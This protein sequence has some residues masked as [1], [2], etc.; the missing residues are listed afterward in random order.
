MNRNAIKALRSTAAVTAAVL[1]VAESAFPM[2]IF[3]GRVAETNRSRQTS[4]SASSAESS[5][6]TTYGI[7]RH[8]LTLSSNGQAVTSVRKGARFSVIERESGRLKVKL[9]DG[10]TGWVDEKGVKVGDDRKPLPAGDPWSTH[11]SIAR[12]AL[13]YRGARYVRG[14][15]GASGFDC[16]GFVRF[17]YNKQGIKLPHSSRGQYSCGRPV[18]KSEL[19]AGDM[20]F[21]G[22]T[23]R[24]GISHVGLYIGD[25]KFIHASTERAGVRVDNLNDAYY[26]RKYAGARRIH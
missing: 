13:S 12:M 6:N 21:F 18:S 4:I 3:L 5:G 9:S 26:R 24:R 22:G 2:R 17:L 15:T 10:Q 1:L 19:R 16:S 8:K 7:S 23:Y 25:G 20:V 14:G 11:G